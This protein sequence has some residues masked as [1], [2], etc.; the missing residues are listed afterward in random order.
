MA[1]NCRTTPVP[2]WM[3]TGDYLLLTGDF[4]VDTTGGNYDLIVQSEE[5]K[6][7]SASLDS[8][9]TIQEKNILWQK[10][11]VIQQNR[12]YN[13][14]LDRQSI[15]ARRHRQLLRARKVEDK[16]TLPTRK[17]RHAKHRRRRR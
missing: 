5:P 2:P 17:G 12:E 7:M 6:K 1:P 15:P 11:V 8:E 9:L 16:R 13:R 14:W 10:D 3:L 4:T